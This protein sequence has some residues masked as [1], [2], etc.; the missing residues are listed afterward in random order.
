[1]GRP[2]TNILEPEQ[3]DLVNQN[4]YKQTAEQ[5]SHQM[6]HED[7]RAAIYQIIV[8]NHLFLSNKVGARS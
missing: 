5:P 1:M 6:A 7:F 4:R 3:I 2:V 8:A